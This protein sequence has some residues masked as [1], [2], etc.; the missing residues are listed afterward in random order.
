MLTVDQVEELGLG[1]K[2][3]DTQTCL[4]VESGLQWLLSNT[5]LRFN[6]NNITEIKALPANVRL[7][8]LKFTEI[9]GLR[10]GVTSESI[11]GLSQSFADADSLNN[12]LWQLA[13]EL[14]G[15]LLKSKVKFVSATQRWR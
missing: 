6:I 8:L 7:F 10:Y 14:L 2:Q 15:D 3:V 9:Y 11:S 5:T 1:L 4:L 12:L 13:D